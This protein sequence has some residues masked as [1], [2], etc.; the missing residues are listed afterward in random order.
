MVAATLT[1]DRTEVQS[2]MPGMHTKEGQK[3]ESNDIYMHHLTCRNN[4]GGVALP[5][6]ENS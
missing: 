6:G 2:Q 5:E 4:L 3:R 1:E